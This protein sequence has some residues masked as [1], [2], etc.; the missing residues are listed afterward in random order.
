LG[1]C[2]QGSGSD[3]SDCYFYFCL[4]LGNQAAIKTIHW[5]HDIL[6]KVG[7]GIVLSNALS[8]FGVDPL[9]WQIVAAIG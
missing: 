4:Y 1:F 5:T 9:W 7:G 8:V 3:L 6:Y 2:H